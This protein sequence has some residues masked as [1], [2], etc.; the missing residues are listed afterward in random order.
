[1]DTNIII[2]ANEITI[3]LK[4]D[5]STIYLGDNNKVQ[6]VVTGIDIIEWMNIFIQTVTN[7]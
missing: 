4:D 3:N 1:M 7:G 6:H 5:K 2:N